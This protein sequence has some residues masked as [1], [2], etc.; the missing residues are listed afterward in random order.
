MSMGHSAGS[1]C[2]TA[3]PSLSFPVPGPRKT[4]P[5]RPSR[6]MTTCEHCGSKGQ[7]VYIFGKHMLTC[8]GN[9]RVATLLC[10]AAANSSSG[11][12]TARH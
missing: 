12:L 11:L 4:G 2:R 1:A 7:R 9:K 8:N 6:E 10:A 5:K 3:P